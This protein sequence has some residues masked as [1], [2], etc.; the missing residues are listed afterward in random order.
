VFEKLRMEKPRRI[1]HAI[2]VPLVVLGVLLSTLHQSSLGSLFLIVPGKLHPL[3]YTPML[4]VFFFISALG[5]GFAMVIFE[6]SLSGKAFGKQLEI[7][8]L[9]DLARVVVVVQLVIVVWRLEDLAS[10]GVLNLLWTGSLPS[11]A[12]LTEI[13]LG[14]LV[15]IV[16]FA[17]P[18]VRRNATGLFVGASFA[19]LGFVLNR[20]NV[21]ITGF[22]LGTGTRYFP[23][24]MEISVTM[25][26]VALG[27]ALFGLAAKHLP[28]FESEEES[29]RRLRRRQLK[30]V[31]VVSV[32]NLT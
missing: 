4:P 17:F 14:S 10:R 3:W 9:G 2:S 32:S 16:L 25:M 28:I 7:P 23:S 18:K 11:V 22:E 30:A 27:F 8:L 12:F 26:I 5:V 31:P 29:G 19:V 21:G 1:L 20:L 24:W 6:S 15:P 13:I